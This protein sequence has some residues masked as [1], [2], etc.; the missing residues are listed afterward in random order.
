MHK[1]N[2]K[3]LKPCPFC[4]GRADL[5]YCINKALVECT[6]KKCKLRPSTWL[7]VDTD[8]VDKLVNIWNQRKYE[9][10]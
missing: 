5:R 9:E 10:E 4:G 1:D 7:R 6:N 2:V 3:F 8:S